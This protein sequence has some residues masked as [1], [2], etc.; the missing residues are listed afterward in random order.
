MFDEELTFGPSRLMASDALGLA[1]EQNKCQ[2]SHWSAVKI[3]SEGNSIKLLKAFSG[4]KKH[5]GHH[6]HT[7]GVLNWTGLS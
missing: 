1:L 6:G 5:K 3:A 2:R 7:Y 4:Q